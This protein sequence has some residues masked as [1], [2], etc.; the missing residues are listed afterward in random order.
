MKAKIGRKTYDTEKS[1]QLGHRTHGTFGDPR[2]FEEALYQ[3]KDGECFLVGQGGASSDY[4]E[5]TVEPLT[6]DAA[7]AWLSEH[8]GTTLEE[9]KPPKQQKASDKPGKKK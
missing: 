2:G 1:K 7:N 6:D 9:L 5:T 4:A 3:R 8:V